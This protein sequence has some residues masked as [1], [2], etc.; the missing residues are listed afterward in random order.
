MYVRVPEDDKRTIWTNADTTNLHFE[1]EIRGS[2]HL[3]TRVDALDSFKG[4][5][6]HKLNNKVIE[7][8]DMKKLQMIMALWWLYWKQTAFVMLHVAL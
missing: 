3:Q 5:Q 8:W 2:M 7:T 4:S 1:R 6:L